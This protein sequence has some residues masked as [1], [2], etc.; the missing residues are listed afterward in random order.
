[1]LV[2]HG[3]NYNAHD[4]DLSPFRAKGSKLIMYH[5]WAD[6]AIPP[7]ASIDYYASVEHQMGGFA[8]TQQFSRLYMVPGGY[9]CLTGGDPGVAADFLTPLINW[10]EQGHPP[11]AV[12]VPVVSQAIGTGLK[13]LT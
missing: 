9:H 2:T 7:F 11:G 12:T 13:S 8:S 4:T 3:S 1:M 5:G 10:V 6:S